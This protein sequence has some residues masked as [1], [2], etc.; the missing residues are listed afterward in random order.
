MADNGVSGGRRMRDVGGTSGGLAPFLFGLAMTLGG[1]YLLISRVW[2]T[3]HS[4]YLFGYDMFGVSLLPLLIGI[5]M[6][7][8]DGKNILAWLLTVAGAAIIILGVIANLSIMFQP[9]SLSN[10]I[11]MLGLMFGGLGLVFK[12][13][14]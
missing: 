3:T 13:L 9:T 2:V 6:L 5:A 12:S 8:Y 10:T 14:R 7:F 4:W 11:I 1:G